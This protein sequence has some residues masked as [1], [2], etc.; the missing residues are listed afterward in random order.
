MGTASAA[1]EAPQALPSVSG[2]WAGWRDFRILSRQYE[3]SSQTQC[4][5]RLE[6]I[7]R[8]P[9]PAF[10]PGQ[11]LTFALPVAS[12][13]TLT[14]CYSLSDGPDSR[15]YRITVKRV[16][17][18]AGRPDLPPGAG[19]SYFHDRI[20]I[21]DV[22]KV[23]APAGHFVLS[24]GI[25]IPIVLIGGGIGI[26][27]LLSMLRG[28][29]AAHSKAAVHLYHGVR[30]G[31]EQA[32]REELEALAREYPAFHLNLVYSQP[33][34]GD[35]L[36]RHYRYKGHIDVHLLR[37]TLP[38]GRHRFY[39]C[40]PPALM[41]S[42]LPALME[43]GVPSED[44]HY[45]AFGPASA[46]SATL[47]AREKDDPVTAPIEILFRKSGRTLTWDGKDVS[48]LDFTERHG[49][50]L[51]SGCRTGNCGACEVKLLSG[52]VRYA[53]KPDHEITP[54]HCLLCVGTPNG[55]LEIDA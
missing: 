53:E 48:L 47:S 11:F 24:P 17:A 20:R 10:Q 28:G 22:V 14:R 30:N 51:E 5:L 27:P 29:L 31:S 49:L 13:R 42:L 37:N 45:E 3:D 4:S 15:G 33:G 36:G 32:F 52:T 9:L 7:D 41:S 44:I 43:W 2:A 18:P 19:S 55:P 40:G 1:V 23:K 25:E 16:P 35:I 34:P 39:L 38:A 12:G 26:T 54:G 50:F 21:G 46:R 6:P 8:A